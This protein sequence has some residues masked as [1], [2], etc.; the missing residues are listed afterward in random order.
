MAEV[1]DVLWAGIN[2]DGSVNAAQTP[3]NTKEAVF[4][5]KMRSYSFWWRR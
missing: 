4:S 5:E 3:D 1:N 2:S